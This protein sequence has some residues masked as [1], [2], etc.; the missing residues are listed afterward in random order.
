MNGPAG[1]VYF[2]WLE[3]LNLLSLLYFH[4]EFLTQ[5]LKDYDRGNEMKGI[6]GSVY[7]EWLE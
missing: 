4:I 5:L 1:S 6:A 2:E 7:F 3:Y